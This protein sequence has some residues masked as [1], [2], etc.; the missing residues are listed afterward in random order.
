MLE[1]AGRYPGP[2]FAV[3]S[4]VGIDYAA[5]VESRADRRLIRVLREMGWSVEGGALSR[6]QLRHATRRTTALL[7]RSGALV[8]G[9]HGPQWEATEVGRRFLRAVLRSG[10]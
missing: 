5:G 3:V 1:L 10:V 4:G 8:D 9:P 2:A 7:Q 6:D